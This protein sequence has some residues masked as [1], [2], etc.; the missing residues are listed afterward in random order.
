MSDFEIRTV[1]GVSFEFVK[2]SINGVDGLI[3][4]KRKVVIPFSKNFEA[5]MFCRDSSPKDFS[6]NPEIQPTHPFLFWNF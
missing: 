2:G 5:I 1:I 3:R 4:S 6:L